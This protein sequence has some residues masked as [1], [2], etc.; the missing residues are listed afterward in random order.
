MYIFITYNRKGM[1][2][3]CFQM[4]NYN[5]K[6]SLQYQN[7]FNDSILRHT[8]VILNWKRQTRCSFLCYRFYS[9][10]VLFM[11]LL[12][13]RLHSS[14][15]QKKRKHLAML[16]SLITQPDSNLNKQGLVRKAMITN[17]PVH[18]LPL[19]LVRETCGGSWG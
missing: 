9:V 14:L 4:S 19:A 15:G 6:K 18:S 11:F 12:I 7:D 10:K 3:G 8:V 17:S 2:I 13:Y 16:E 5:K 1:D